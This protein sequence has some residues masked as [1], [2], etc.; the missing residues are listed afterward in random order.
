MKC[1]HYWML[2]ECPR[3]GAMRVKVRERWAVRLDY[4]VW[5]FSCDADHRELFRSLKTAAHLARKRGGRV[6]RI[7]TYEVLR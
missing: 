7:T 1:E 2:D 4:G 5:Q 3:C 6:V